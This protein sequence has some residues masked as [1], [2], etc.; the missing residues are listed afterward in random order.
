MLLDRYLDNIRFEKIRPGE[1]RKRTENLPKFFP[2]Q[3]SA[4]SQSFLK[5]GPAVSVQLFLY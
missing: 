4:D 3:G 5:K 2:K 1:D